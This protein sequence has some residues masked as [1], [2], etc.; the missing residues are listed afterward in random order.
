[1][2]DGTGV[3]SSVSIL[4][5]M[6]VVLVRRQQMIDDVEALLAR[7][8]VDRGDVDEA[9]ELAARIVAQEGHDLDDVARASP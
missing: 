9:D 7:R 5:R 6:R 3:S 8:P 4:T 1:M 2:I